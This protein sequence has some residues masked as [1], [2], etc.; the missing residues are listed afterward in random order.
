MTKEIYLSY[1]SLKKIASN[2]F[3]FESVLQASPH[4][5]F[6]FVNNQWSVNTPEKRPEKTRIEM[7]LEQ[8]RKARSAYTM[9]CKL[10]PSFTFNPVFPET[11]IERFMTNELLTIFIPWGVSDKDYIAERETQALNIIQQVNTYFNENGIGTRV[12][13]M[14]ADIY[15]L[16][17]NNKVPPTIVNNYFNLLTLE[18]EKRDLL[19]RPWSTIRKNNQSRYIHLANEFSNLRIDEVISQPVRN[20]AELAA[21]KNSGFTNPEEIR[22]SAYNYLRER[23]CEAIIIEETLKPIKISLAPKHKDNDV[24]MNLPRLYI[25]PEHLILP[26]KGKV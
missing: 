17:I 15:A 25:F 10:Q 16:E 22:Q 23:I 6:Y 7:N 26:W 1:T 12:L 18:A 5:R 11:V 14:P 2:R 19:V 4:R 13:L 24:D 21:S 3:A 20:K 8:F 9:W